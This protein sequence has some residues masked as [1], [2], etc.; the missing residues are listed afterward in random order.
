MVKRGDALEFISLQV[1]GPPLSPNVSG[2]DIRASVR[3]LQCVELLR[4]VKRSRASQKHRLAVA[5][6]TVGAGFGKALRGISVPFPAG[7][8][9][10]LERL[11]VR[12]RN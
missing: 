8:A 4:G 10:A 7:T 12:L 9:E 1:H 11:P 5:T 2:D 3:V 6:N